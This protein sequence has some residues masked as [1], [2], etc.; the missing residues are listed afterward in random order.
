MA[1]EIKQQLR[2]SQQLVM[3]PQLQ[4]AIKLLQLSQLELSD[5]VQQELQDNVV[6]EESIEGAEDLPREVVADSEE[7][8]TPSS[9]ENSDV[10]E[11]REASNAEKIADIDWQSYAE[12]YPQTGFQNE[13]REDDERRSLE[14]TLTRRET[15]A[16][17]MNWQLQLSDL[18]V[19]LDDG[20]WL[21]EEC[22]S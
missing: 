13:T 17:H 1:I 12:A 7:A 3:T 2:L 16:E 22:G 21:D 8:P 10:P 5:L 11:N 14:G 20:Q 18:V 19:V 6:L 9:E 15:L 4:Q